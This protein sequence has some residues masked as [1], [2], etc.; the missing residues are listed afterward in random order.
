MSNAKISQKIMEQLSREQKQLHLNFF[1]KGLLD[2]IDRF[3]LVY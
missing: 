1:E 2:L 3:T